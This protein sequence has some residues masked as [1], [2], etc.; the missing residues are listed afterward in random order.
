MTF[1]AL[2]KAG[3]RLHI[4][5]QGLKN[6]LMKYFKRKFLNFAPQKTNKSSTKVESLKIH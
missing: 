1:P 4:R 5:S 2:T 3:Q 6:Y